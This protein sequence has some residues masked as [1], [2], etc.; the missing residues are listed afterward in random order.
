M[1][2]YIYNVF[3]TFLKDGT[4]S[5]FSH[6]F[7]FFEFFWGF[8]ALKVPSSPTQDKEFWTCGQPIF[9]VG[10]CWFS[11]RFGWCLATHGFSMAN[12]VAV[13][14]CSPDWISLLCLFPR[15]YGSFPQVIS[16]NS[17]M[18][19]EPEHNEI[20]VHHCRN[21]THFWGPKQFHKQKIN[22]PSICSTD[23]KRM[24][25]TSFQTLFH[26]RKKPA[27]CGRATYG[28]CDRW[29][30]GHMKISSCGIS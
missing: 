13:P 18:G 15:N 23:L 7:P 19:F 22:K 2:V 29:L 27:F 17:T 11:Q 28:P 1:C 26:H 10:W 25:L 12:L 4:R 3:S 14:R 5:T 16:S 6:H 9:H 21:F 8:E 24:D 20:D 30:E